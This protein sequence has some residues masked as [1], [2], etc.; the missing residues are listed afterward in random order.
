MMQKLM[1]RMMLSCQKA[2][3]LTEKRHHAHLSTKQHI[4]LYLHTSMCS[5][6]KEYQKQSAALEQLFRVKEKME[7]QPDSKL[8]TRQLEEKIIKK[9]KEK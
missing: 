9:L 1:M 8:D 7:L 4:Q 3:E 6:C 2:T 5:A